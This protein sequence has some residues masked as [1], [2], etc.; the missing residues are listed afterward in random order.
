[1]KYSTVIAAAAAK[2]TTIAAISAALVPPFLA[3]AIVGRSG[4][5][6]RG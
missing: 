5:V 2:V 6:L 4:R 1:M 3:G